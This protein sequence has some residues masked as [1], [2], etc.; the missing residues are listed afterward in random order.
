MTQPSLEIIR[1]STYNVRILLPS[2]WNRLD[3]SNL[4]YELLDERF[5]NIMVIERDKEIIAHWALTP[6]YHAEG[7]WIRPDYRGNP[8]IVRK[9]LRGMKIMAETVDAPFVI[10]NTSDEKV[11]ELLT[12]IEAEKLTGDYFAITFGSK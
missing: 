7:I 4:N 2:E 12:K 8:T 6:I 10:T 11:K 5:T 3:K 9:L 1:S